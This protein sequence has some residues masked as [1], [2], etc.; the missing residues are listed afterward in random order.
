MPLPAPAAIASLIWQYRLR[1]YGRTAAYAY[2][3][4]YNFAVYY[5]LGL[6]AVFEVPA[7]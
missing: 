2:D 7:T 3:V 4:G 1:A 6:A 5:A